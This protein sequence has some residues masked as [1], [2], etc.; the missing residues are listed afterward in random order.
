MSRTSSQGRFWFVTLVTLLAIAT[1]ASL[2]RW[3]LNRAA[4]KERLAEQRTERQALPPL[5]WAELS[6]ADSAQNWS[7][8]QGR[9][10]ELQ[11]YWK[12]EAT[13]FLENRPM[14]GRAGFWV[15]TPLWDEVQRQAVLVV[16]GWVPRRL[17]DRTA[18]PDFEE[19][20]EQVRVVGRLAPPPSKLY[21]F[22]QA[23]AG[24]IRQNIDI[25]AF[26][27]EWSL[28]LWP[29]SVEQ[30]DSDGAEAGL[31]RGWPLPD[32]DVHKHYGY[33]FQWFG[34]TTLLIFLYVWFQF[35]GPWKQRRDAR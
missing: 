24:R 5:N 32:S 6:L 34:L 30:M 33:A 17:D 27:N 22:G 1:T 3:Q 12:H 21:D 19:S 28:R 8:Y 31:L 18:V 13:V 23:G 10:V 2:G 11:G 9:R 7:D 4:E 25:D 15:V 14:N 20:S 29:V 16:R 26:G 35:I